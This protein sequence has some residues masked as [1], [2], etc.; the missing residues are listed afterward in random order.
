MLVHAFDRTSANRSYDLDGRLH[1]A[2]CR[3]SRAAVNDYR[4][5]E[6]PDYEKLGLDANRTYRLFR[7][8][9]ELKSAAPTFDNL[10]IL[11]EHCPVDAVDYRPDLVCGA[12]AADSKF[13]APFLENGIV[14][15]AADVIR[16]IESGEKKELSA[17]YRFVADM[18]PGRTDEGESFDGVMRQLCGNHIAVVE[19]GRCGPS[20][21]VGDTKT[22]FDLDKFYKRFPDMRR[23]GVAL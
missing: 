12:T 17:S 18:T 14:I 11:R 3:I 16:D 4:G 21:V 9:E 13:S 10:P 23:I 6:I 19:S 1:V 22:T 20:V 5:D 2:A 15:W 7:A 8:S